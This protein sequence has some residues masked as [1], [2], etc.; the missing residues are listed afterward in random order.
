MNL[1]IVHKNHIHEIN[2]REYQ[3]DRFVL[4]QFSIGK[5]E[6][7]F[8]AVFDGHGGSNISKF[9]KKEF[10]DIFLEQIKT[11]DVEQNWNNKTKMRNFFEKLFFSI[12][13]DYFKTYG[14]EDA[15]STAT[16]VFIPL[17]T[18]M[19]HVI[20]VCNLGDS[21]TIV[22]DKNGNEIMKDI[23]NQLILAT[24]DHKPNY[25]VEEHRIKANNGYITY[26]YGVARV[27]DNL[28][29]SRGFGDFIY[30]IENEKYL[31]PNFQLVSVEPDVYTINLDTKNFDYPLNILLASDGLWDIM[32]N[33]EIINFY[34]KELQID[35][36]YL[37]DIKKKKFEDNTTIL[38]FQVENL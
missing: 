22:F 6:F 1:K 7:F 18:K 35:T 11:Y 27:N 19:G 10:F 30:K 15:G 2:T 4:N 28:A 9:L 36:K 16:M 33:E 24:I 5:N 34:K 20:Y 3:E 25:P 32:T 26:P 14:E 8:A 31:K 29:V 17:N 21:R 12:D 37:F 13:E 38:Y 23:E